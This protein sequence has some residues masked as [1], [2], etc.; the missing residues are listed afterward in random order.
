MKKLVITIVLLSAPILL[1]CQT[2]NKQEESGKSFTK[3][4][5]VEYSCKSTELSLEKKETTIHDL[6]SLCND[7]I[8]IT[9][10]EKAVINHTTNKVTIYNWEMIS[11]KGAIVTKIGSENR[12][13]LEY[14][15]GEDEVYLY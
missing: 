1:F 9:N 14:T 11:F 5:V 12:R 10:A 3:S 13:I 2:Q 8:V 15:I 7:K 6:F 4:E